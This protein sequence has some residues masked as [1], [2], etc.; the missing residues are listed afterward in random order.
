MKIETKKENRVMVV[1]FQ[2]SLDVSNQTKLKDTLAGIADAGESDVVFDFKDVNFIDSSC[3]G[4]LVA[5]TKRLREIKGDIKLTGLSDD[6][7]SIFQITRLDRIFEIFASN[8]EAVDSFY[9]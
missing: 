9:R 5:I 6:V 8:K 1:T 7:R 4:V 2:G 3:L